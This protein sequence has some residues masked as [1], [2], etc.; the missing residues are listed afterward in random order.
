MILTFFLRALP[1]FENDTGFKSGSATG[2]TGYIDITV[3]S[4][5]DRQLFQYNL[6]QNCLS[7]VRRSD[8]TN[9]DTSLISISIPVKDFI[10]SNKYVYK[11]FLTLLKA[12][13]YPFLQID[14]PN[15]LINNLNSYDSVILKGV[16]LTVA[17]VSKRYDIGCT[18][19]RSENRNRILDGT[20]RIKLT[21]LG[22]VPPVKMLGLI[23]VKNE[24]IV[25]F[26][27]CLGSA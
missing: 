24:I 7:A 21:D 1:C 10:C 12:D 16:S 9:A 3:T 26:Q 25:S 19:K 15:S 23:K 18:I 13:H 4:N 2:F 5:I 6:K 14:L 8:M 22:L 11:D 17:G 27:F 20:T